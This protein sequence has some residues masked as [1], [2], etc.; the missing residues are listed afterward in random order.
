MTGLTWNAVQQLP[1]HIY[2]IIVDD[3]HRSARA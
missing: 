3:L 1:E 2:S